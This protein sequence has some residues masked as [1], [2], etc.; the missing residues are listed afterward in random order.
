MEEENFQI[1]TVCNLTDLPEVLKVGLK[2]L[3][4]KVIFFLGKF[5]HAD[6][7]SVSFD[8][9]IKACGFRIPWSDCETVLLKILRERV[10]IFIVSNFLYEEHLDFADV[11][12]G[13]R[14][15]PRQV[16][17]DILYKLLPQDQCRTIQWLSDLDRAVNNFPEAVEGVRDPKDWLLNLESS[18]FLSTSLHQP[19]FLRD[20]LH[21][22]SDALHISSD[23]PD[24][25]RDALHIS[26]GLFLIKVPSS[27][28]ISDSP[29]LFIHKEVLGRLVRNP[30]RNVLDSGETGS[31]LLRPLLLRMR[32]GDGLDEDLPQLIRILMVLP[33]GVVREEGGG[34]VEASLYDDI[35][36]DANNLA[37]LQMEFGPNLIV[38]EFVSSLWVED[39]LESFG[40]SADYRVYRCT[41]S[42]V[43]GK[44]FFFLRRKS[45]I[46]FTLNQKIF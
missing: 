32:D 21:I 3:H 11:V 2:Q 26:R 31:T 22:S 24:I 5:Y 30:V 15:S 35:M 13:S 43:D 39:S 19:I 38:V 17:S 7:L 29:Y 25:S 40:N 6:V 42:A 4:G 46:G 10:D 33:R 27:R 14:F 34:V 20:A 41:A 44:F 1:A 37:R 9:F 8:V 23:A 36:E 12:L 28:R 16:Y 45:G 18:H